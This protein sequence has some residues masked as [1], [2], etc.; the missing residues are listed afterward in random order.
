MERQPASAERG[1]AEPLAEAP[2]RRPARLPPRAR[3]CGRAPPRGP[4]QAAQPPR[5]GRQPLR[6]PPP[7]VNPSDPRRLSGLAAALAGCPDPLSLE[8]PWPAPGQAAMALGHSSASGLWAAPPWG[9]L[10]RQPWRDPLP[11][12]ARAAAP[13]R[14]LWEVAPVPRIAL[15]VA[16]RLPI[17]GRRSRGHHGA[18]YATAQASFSP[19][20]PVR[21]SGPNFGSRTSSAHF[22]PA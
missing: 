19:A 9:P 3:R 18:S 2:L 15:E 7:Q 10:G 11:K 22:H 21:Q 8:G 17:R 20:W 16:A 6:A 1:T 12:R 13:R 14:L 4:G 5:P